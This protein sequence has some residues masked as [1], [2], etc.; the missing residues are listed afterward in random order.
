MC[1]A[2]KRLTLARIRAV[3]STQAI[4]HGKESFRQRIV[5]KYNNSAARAGRGTGAAS[6]CF[7]WVKKKCISC[8]RY[9]ARTSSLT[10]RYANTTGGLQKRTEEL[11][12]SR[13]G[14]RERGGGREKNADVRSRLPII[15][16]A[17]STPA[18]ERLTTTCAVRRDRS[19]LF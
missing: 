13:K 8:S 12:E 17:S 4:A 9:L 18:R 1:D 6:R 10:R 7:A 5:K 3:N 2:V 11:K 19:R 15:P 14:E 16:P